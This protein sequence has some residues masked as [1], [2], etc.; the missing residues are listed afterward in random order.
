MA[1]DHKPYSTD[2]WVE[3][4]FSLKG[5]ASLDTSFLRTAEGSI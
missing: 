5:T 3:Q 2:D 4:F 1:R